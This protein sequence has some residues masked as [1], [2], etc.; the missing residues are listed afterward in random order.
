[1]AIRSPSKVGYEIGDY[2]GI[3]FANA[4]SDSASRS[5]QASSDMAMS[6]KD[7]LLK[8]IAAVSA[9]SFDT[10][11]I[12]P[13]VRPVLD[14]SNIQNGAR[15]LYSMVGGMT[16]ALPIGSLNMASQVQQSLNSRSVAVDDAVP[17]AINGLE[18]AIKDLIANPPVHNENNFSI[19]SDDPEEI[20]RY[21]SRQIWKEVSRR[22]S[23]WE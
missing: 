18:K 6:A 23:Q 9:V 5:Y 7:G 8:A 22:S 3:G 2:F 15:T 16:S 14:L 12:E 20:A 4:L 21:V 13:T 10:L 17:V 11:E 19:T 1:M